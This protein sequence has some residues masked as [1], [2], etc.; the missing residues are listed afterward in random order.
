MVPIG[1]VMPDSYASRVNGQDDRRARVRAYP[2]TA[3]VIRARLFLSS[4]APLFAIFAARAAPGTAATNQPT[5][6]FV[7]AL[8]ISAVGFADAW[9]L[10]R[11][12]NR[13]NGIRVV[14]NHVQEQ[15][16]AV[17]G[18][19]PTYL[20]PFIGSAPSTVGAWIGYGIYIL[21]LFVVFLSS[22]FA[23]VNPTLYLLG[24]RIARV[25]RERQPLQA[26]APAR[27]EEILLIAKH[28]PRP[29][30]PINVTQLAGCWVE[31]GA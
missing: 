6:P 8:I 31:K 18:Y 9:W 24:R 20:L 26:G 21:V 5:W 1:S 10:I 12:A 19:L 23:L 2:I 13:R 15:G 17:A 7:V 28:L 3:F 4:Y 29:G 25:T 22:D 30:E 14:P 27:E 11:G 16:A